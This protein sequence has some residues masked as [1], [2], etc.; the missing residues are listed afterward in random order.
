MS[1]IESS[2]LVN[3]DQG[4]A[5]VALN[6]A[7]VHNAFDANLIG[8]LTTTL[9]DLGRNDECR[10]VV[11][12]GRGASFSAGADVNWMQ[13]Q[14][15]AT[16]LENINDARSLAQLMRTLAY[17][18]K[19]TIARV[20]GPAYGGGVGLIACC[21]IAVGVQDSRFGLTETKLGLVPAVISPYVIDAIGMRQALRYFQTGELFDA[22]RAQHIGLLHEVVSAEQLDAVV[23]QLIRNLRQAGPIAVKSSKSLVHRVIGLSIEDQMFTD[24]ENAKLIAKL[25]ISSEGQEGLSAFL[26]KRKAS[27]VS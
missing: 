2:V 10:V 16:E 5:T 6:R 12:T 27:W 4:I 25:R 18:P 14:L 22:A 7:S 9:S 1:A 21:D 20:N 3:L 11:L 24:E 8:A 15:S 23:A 13:S 26:S 19:T 17:L